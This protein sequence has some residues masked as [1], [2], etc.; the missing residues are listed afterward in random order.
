[1]GRAARHWA[2]TEEPTE[3]STFSRACRLH[4]HLGQLHHGPEE[5]PDHGE[6]KAKALTSPGLAG[7][8]WWNK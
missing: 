1:M 8:C 3:E 5:S 7:Q 6:V 4:A 2:G